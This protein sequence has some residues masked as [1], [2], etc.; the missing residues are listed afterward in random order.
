MWSYV[1]KT[2]ENN[3]AHTLAF[4]QMTTKYKWQR[5]TATLWRV[6][7]EIV[8]TF[9]WFL[10]FP[11][12]V[13]ICSRGVALEGARAVHALGRTGG[14]CMLVVSLYSFLYGIHIYT[15]TQSDWIW[16]WN[17]NNSRREKLRGRSRVGQ[18]SGIFDSAETSLSPWEGCDVTYKTSQPA[19]P[20]QPGGLDTRST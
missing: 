10:N 1:N 2:K 18:T 5:F 4:T 9:V 8:R 12:Q 3:S 15:P 17:L 11:G 20:N 7:F 14:N 13:V 6:D 19:Q 16:L